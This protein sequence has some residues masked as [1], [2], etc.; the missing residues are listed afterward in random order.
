MRMIPFIAALLLAAPAYAHDALGPHGGRQV[1]A[2]TKHVELLTKGAGIEVFVADAEG[3]LAD[4]SALKGIAILMVG[5]KPARIP[6]SPAGAEKLGGTAAA[7]I[8]QPA[9]GAVLITSPDGETAQGK[10]N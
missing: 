2:G 1:D 10:F 7:D 4:A 3:K 6:L 5:G 8:D 9:K